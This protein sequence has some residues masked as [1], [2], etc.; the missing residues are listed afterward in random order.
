MY[1]RTIYSIFAMIVFTLMAEVFYIV[2]FGM[3]SKNQGLSLFSFI[4][5]DSKF[6]WL[7]IALL[8][9]A[10]LST[11]LAI[12]QAL[13]FSIVAAL[14]LTRA[15]ECALFE[16]E[17]K[18]V[19]ETINKLDPL[20]K[21]LKKFVQL[22]NLVSQFERGFGAK[23]VGIVGAFFALS[24]IK[25][26]CVYN[27][28]R[29]SFDV[30]PALAYF[31]SSFYFFIGLLLLLRLGDS[32]KSAVIHF[33]N[34]KTFIKFIH[35]CSKAFLVFSLACKSGKKSGLEIYRNNHDQSR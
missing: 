27:M 4:S 13:L 15:L 3:E 20:K 17:Q 10:E 12:A 23:I 14:H 31:S 21:S 25:I 7:G 29:T 26:Y 33:P 32:M 16:W 19:I 5:P 22:R 34:L 9:F 2:H 28:S 35:C 18:L 30:S 11:E 1:M 8:T 24:T 6:Y